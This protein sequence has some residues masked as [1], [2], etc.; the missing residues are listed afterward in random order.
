MSKRV[1]LVNRQTNEVENIIFLWECPDGYD[2]VESEDAQIGWVKVGATLKKSQKI[3]DQETAEEQRLEEKRQQQLAAEQEK[4]DKERV[5]QEKVASKAALK[6]R[7]L[8]ADI[9]QED[10]LKELANLL[11]SE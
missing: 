7:I 2:V 4:A 11:L 8:S 1:A 10:A 5:R 3:I 6:S 9:N